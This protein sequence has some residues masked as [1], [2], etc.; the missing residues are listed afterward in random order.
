MFLRKYLKNELMK[1]TKYNE[2]NKVL[3]FKV[4]KRANGPKTPTYDEDLS[5][6]S[7]IRLF[8]IMGKRLQ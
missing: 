4:S 6:V 5:R 3:Y 8:G 7:S 1:V 2:E